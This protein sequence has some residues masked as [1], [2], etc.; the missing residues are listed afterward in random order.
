MKTLTRISL[1]AGAGWLALAG[2][3]WAEEGAVAKKPERREVWVPSEDLETVLK[4]HPNAVLLDRE[5][6]ERLVRDA[7][8]VS[9]E[10]EEKP[11][12]DAVLESVKMKAAPTAGAES[13][14]LEV[15]LTVSALKE[16]WSSVVL[17]GW[18]DSVLLQSFGGVGATMAAKDGGERVVAVRGRGRHVVQMV[19]VLPVERKLGFPVVEVPFFGNPGSLLVAPGEG[20]DLWNEIVTELDGTKRVVPG[21][22]G[23]G[24]NSTILLKWREGKLTEADEEKVVTRSLAVAEVSTTEVVTKVQTVFL[25]NAW[26]PADMLVF[27]LPDPEAQVLQVRASGSSEIVWVQKGGVVEVR[28]VG[29][30]KLYGLDFVLSKS[31]P[32]G[33]GGRADF[34]MDVPRLRGAGQSWFR[35]MLVLQEGVESSGWDEEDGELFVP[36]EHDRA[37]A[38]AKPAVMAEPTVMGIRFAVMPEKVMAKVRRLGD[39]FSVDADLL[40]KLG[41]HE[42]ALTRTLTF[43]GEE[44]GVGRTLLTLPI[45]EKFIGMETA[46]ELKPQWKRVGQVGIEIMWPKA[47]TRGAKTVYTLR[48]RPELPNL[49]GG[50]AVLEL[51]N[52]EVKEASRVAGYVAVDF[53]E[54]WRVSPL[55]TTGLE[56]R[57]GRTTPVRGKMA[58]FTLREFGLELS[59]ARHEPLLDAMVTAYALPRARVVEIEGQVRVAVSRAPLRVVEVKFPEAVSGLVRWDSPL[60]GERRLDAKSGVWTLTL[61]KELLGAENLRF[62]V[63]LPAVESGDG[64]AKVLKAALPRMAMPKAR[65]FAGS[66]VI[67]ANTDT[68]LAFETKGLQ[69]MDA[70]RAPTV[71]GYSARHRVLAV[72][73]FGASEHELKLTATRH[74]STRLTSA[75]VTR[76]EL[77]SVVGLDGGARHQAVM[78][79]KHSGD[80]FFAMRLPDRA[81]LLSAM[82]D[83][84][85]VKPISAG[86]GEVRLP[87]SGRGDGSGVV[88]KVIYQTQSGVWASRGKQAFRPPVF[89]AVVPVLKT[90]WQV[91]APEGFSYR[92]PR[93][94]LSLVRGGEEAR[95]LWNGWASK[96]VDFVAGGGAVKQTDMESLRVLELTDRMPVHRVENEID[97]G[98]ESKLRQLLFPSVQF[99]DASLE[100]ALE[101]LRIKSRDFDAEERDPAKK[102]LRVIESDSVKGKGGKITLDLR[103][104]PMDEALRYVTELAGVGFEIEGGMVVVKTLEEIEGRLRT[105]EWHGVPS[106]GVFAG[107]Q[108]AQAIDVLKGLGFAFNEGATAEYEPRSGRLTMT[109]RKAELDGVQQWLYQWDSALRVQEEAKF[110]EEDA[111]IAYGSTIDDS[112]YY[113]SKMKN[114]ILPELKLSGVPMDKAIEVLRVKSREHDSE[115]RDPARK[116]V[117]F[118][119]R[120]NGVPSTATISLELKDVP[121][122]EALRYVTELANMK[123]R[124]EKFAV[125]VVPLSE[126]GEEMYSKV[127]TVAPDFLGA[128][129]NAEDVLKRGGITFPEGAS[130]VFSPSTSQLM[131]RNT[132]PNVDAVDA[133]V[134]ALRMV[135][136]VAPVEKA[137]LLPVELDLPVAGRRFEFEGA[138]KPEV[139]EFSYV[140]WRR[141]MVGAC[142]W[143]VVGAGAFWALGR[144][145]PWAMTLAAVILLTCVPLLLSVSWWAV[146]NAVLAGWLVAG[147]VRFLWGLAWWVEGLVLM[148]LNEPAA[149]KE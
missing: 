102:G 134:G 1:L 53:D 130:A 109:N 23:R 77:Q 91:H 148:N 36:T 31:L 89:D 7:G 46:C 50:S 95:S 104:V 55:K 75:V 17:P 18:P 48:T 21:E 16:G 84:Q 40:A 52:V 44:G 45:G 132:Q 83:L 135:T 78:R 20:V 57:D 56:E 72:Y 68:E 149:V 108:G 146:L 60:I 61:R 107:I 117:N 138:M 94:S 80:Q 69:P 42:V 139:L 92:E 34:A 144:R 27:D 73:G 74:E 41:Q 51:G 127:F 59:M 97:R 4:A 13:L 49:A 116:G 81:A 32:V 140:S 76:L 22:Q 85:P 87:L 70:L 28:K 96:S 86:E 54:G 123:Y 121:L 67:E 8:V 47:L 26:S 11:P 88:I 37:M 65:R 12:V 10:E 111:G 29:G 122:D 126:V 38:A 93:T 112:S 3:L 125:V 137:G 103:E 62:H 129:A 145:S 30:S 120:L 110:K 147:L 105:A 66:W 15:E 19:M 101:F 33:V 5:S 2:G 64:E 99:K 71:E 124:V 90:S 63:S 142:L 25:M 9:E 136:M 79:V 35:L 141:Q 106:T 131:V 118:V 128:D 24:E 114:I 98:A 143:M 113:S 6:Y 119:L 39:R 82:V 133:Y 58:W 115:E 14:A 100:E 43:H